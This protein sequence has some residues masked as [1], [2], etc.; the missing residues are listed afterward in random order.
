MVENSSKSRYLSVGRS[1]YLKV[2][3]QD[4][5]GRVFA[6]EY[7]EFHN[8]IFS[9][10]PK[11]ASVEESYDSVARTTHLKV[12]GKSKGETL[13]YVRL[14]KTQPVIFDVFKVTVDDFVQ[15]Y[16]NVKVHE[17]GEVMFKTYADQS[18][19]HKGWISSNP[20]I[21]AINPKTGLAIGIAAGKA[22]VSYESNV[23]VEYEVEVF[24]VTNLRLNN[25]SVL[26]L[27][28]IDDDLSAHSISI[29]FS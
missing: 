23:K 24:R 29:S 15:T 20:Q 16:E 3:I 14:D 6:Q 19:S 2:S 7:S 4:E 17:G 13:I 8:K 25:G 28:N 12:T 10:N 18:E 5:L 9:T 22:T 27:S 26:E 21:L 11:I 1:V